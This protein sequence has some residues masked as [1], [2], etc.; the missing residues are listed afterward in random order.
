MSQGG[1]L[2]MSDNEVRDSLIE[3]IK[4]LKDNIMRLDRLIDKENV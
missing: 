4:I 2:L 1:L 3:T